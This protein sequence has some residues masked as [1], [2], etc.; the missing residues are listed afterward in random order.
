M[1]HL[2]NCLHIP[3]IL[4]INIDLSLGKIM[5][6][7]SN[8]KTNYPSIRI[9]ALSKEDNS[10]K[11]LKVLG[12]GVKG[13]LPKYVEKSLLEKA[14]KQIMTVGVFY[15]PEVSEL[16]IES[17]YPNKKK[18]E[19]LKDR[20]IEFVKHACTEKTYKEIAKDMCVSP[21]TIEGY[22]DAIFEKLNVKNRTGMVI[23]AIKND[24][25]RP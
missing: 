19:E 20:E 8:L 12:A 3:D 9:I 1:T 15:T 25:F 21:R 23:Y 22:R 7:I 13:Y 6:T 17:L 18:M 14:M 5:N 11:I 24:I 10:R 2:S 16:L 4:L